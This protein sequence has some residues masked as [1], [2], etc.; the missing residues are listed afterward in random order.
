MQA[1]IEGD[2]EA[3]SEALRG[4]T[5]EKQGLEQRWRYL[6]QFSHINKLLTEK[7]QEVSYFIQ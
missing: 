7:V 1:K 3:L 4:L 2:N 6:I 5:Q